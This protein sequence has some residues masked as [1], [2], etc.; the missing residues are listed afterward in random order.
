MRMSSSSARGA[1]PSLLRRGVGV[2]R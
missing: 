1:G 2:S